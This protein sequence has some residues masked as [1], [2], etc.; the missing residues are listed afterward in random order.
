MLNTEKPC[1]E[2]PKTSRLLL[3]GRV[4]SIFEKSKDVLTQTIRP[5]PF[6]LVGGRSLRMT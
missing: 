3:S 5:P 1:T 2:M 4:T 6:S